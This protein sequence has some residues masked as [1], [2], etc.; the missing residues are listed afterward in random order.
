MH[1]RRRLGWVGVRPRYVKIGA[2]IISALGLMG[3]SGLSVWQR[4][5]S[6]WAW[7]GSAGGPVKAQHGGSIGGF[8]E[9]G[10]ACR[11]SKTPQSETNHGARFELVERHRCQSRL[12]PL[13]AFGL[14]PKFRFLRNKCTYTKMASDQA[15]SIVQTALPQCCHSALIFPGQ[16]SR[17]L[18][19]RN[20]FLLL[21]LR[22]L[23]PSPAGLI[24][25]CPADLLRS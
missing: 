4:W 15:R 17:A 25:R 8:D 19:P 23:R 12:W 20:L 22:L 14:S 18:F 16:S 3:G 1:T 6:S 5:T 10:I 9:F 21:L 11:S 13:L 2:S 7:G 24:F